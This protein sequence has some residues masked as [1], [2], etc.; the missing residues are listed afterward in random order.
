MS[1]SSHHRTIARKNRRSAQIPSL[2]ESEEPVA[3][4]YLND[5]IAMV[6]ALM[7]FFAFQTI[8]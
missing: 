5:S 8:R 1:D 2:I 3:M 6:F 4:D 7:A